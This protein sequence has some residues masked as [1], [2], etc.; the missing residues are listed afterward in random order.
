MIDDSNIANYADD[1][2]PFVSRDTSL[3]VIASLENAVEKLFE[4]FTN[5]HMKANHDKCH[6]LMR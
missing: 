4:R 5:N 6:L 2:T 3:N 1:N